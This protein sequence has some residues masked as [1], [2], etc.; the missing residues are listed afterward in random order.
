MRNSGVDAGCETQINY[1]ADVNTGGGASEIERRH[2]EVFAFCKCDLV[3]FERGIQRVF[4]RAANECNNRWRC[5]HRKATNTG[6]LRDGAVT[7]V[8]ICISLCITGEE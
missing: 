2:C 6:C 1:F 4:G 7:D 8:R 5:R 3:H